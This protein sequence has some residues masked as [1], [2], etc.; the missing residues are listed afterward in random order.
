MK[1]KE[2]MSHPMKTRFYSSSEGR[3]C[4]GGCK[5]LYIDYSGRL[6]C[7]PYRGHLLALYSEF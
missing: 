7:L 2:T 1:E 5:R 3:I 6:I 4:Q